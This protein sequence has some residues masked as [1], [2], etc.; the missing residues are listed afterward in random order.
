MQHFYDKYFVFETPY[1]PNTKKARK[2][3][4]K[5]VF[6]P[7]AP[8]EIRLFEYHSAYEI[9][10]QAALLLAHNPLLPP[11]NALSI[12]TKMLTGLDESLYKAQLHK[13][14][15]EK[16]GSYKDAALLWENF[17]FLL[18]DLDFGEI[19]HPFLQESFLPH[20]MLLRALE[21]TQ[22]CS[23]A[24]FREEQSGRCEDPTPSQA[25]FFSPPKI[26]HSAS[27]K[28]QAYWDFQKKHAA[29]KRETQPSITL[30]YAKYSKD[31]I[32]LHE[33]HFFD[34]A[35][36]EIQERIF[37]VS[38]W[39]ELEMQSPKLSKEQGISK[40]VLRVT[41][42]KSYLDGHTQS[43]ALLEFDYINCF[44]KDPQTDQIFAT[45]KS[46][47]QK[48]LG[49]KMFQTLCERYY[50]LFGVD[51]QDENAIEHLSREFTF[52]EGDRGAILH[53]REFAI[54]PRFSQK[55]LPELIKALYDLINFHS[56]SSFPLFSCV[57]DGD[58][59][60]NEKLFPLIKSPLCTLISSEFLHTKMQKLQEQ[61]EYDSHYRSNPFHY[62]SKMSF[63]PLRPIL[64]Y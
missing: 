61:E 14:F 24:A 60:L 54:A 52:D 17:N 36:K 63:D 6:V 64:I 4:S 42:A 30:Y 13:L 2:E 29:F 44:Y 9:R 40:G 46:D 21:S 3:L 51:A 49:E 23:L 33:R 41:V 45:T 1:T 39:A 38:I 26:L 34:Y 18:V 5:S 62:Y 15:L 20:R 53:L 56:G 32:N 50:A 55:I 58:I 43:I 31:F 27:Q 19:E 11:K 57:F 28:L 59:I 8:N 16:Q 47:L 10:D 25:S 12:A 37:G 22:N 7:T 48:F 35:T